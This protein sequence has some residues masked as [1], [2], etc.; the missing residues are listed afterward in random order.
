MSGQEK[1]RVLFAVA[2]VGLGN[3]TR[4]EAI[5]RELGDV[6]VRVLSFGNAVRHLRRSG[7]TVWPMLPLLLPGGALDFL[8][9]MP[10]NL[11]VW[12]VNMLVCFVAIVRFRPRLVVVDSEYS[13]ILPALL[14]GRRMVGINGAALVEALWPRMKR[15]GLGWSYWGR[16]WWDARIARVFHTTLTPTFSSEIP[17]PEGHVPVPPIVRPLPAG[18]SEE[19]GILVLRGGS[20]H[21]TP[22]TLPADVELT[23]IGGRNVVDDS[24]ERIARASI[25]VC[26]GGFS[27][28]SEVLALGKKALVA[29]LPGHVEQEF[30]ARV[31]EEMGAV[32]VFDG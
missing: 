32:R 24:L 19:G 4:S 29:P 2:G 16:E 13:V 3:A 11:V 22:L 18:R 21:E 12:L 30:N 10:L 5:L 26:Q 8:W 1:P 27:S 14:T 31:L 17:L 7:A 15:P 25:V 20:L 9:K 28:L 23:E 6:D